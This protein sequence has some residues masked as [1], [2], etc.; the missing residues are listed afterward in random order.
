MRPRS[1]WRTT[2]RQRSADCSPTSNVYFIHTRRDRGFSPALPATCKWMALRYKCCLPSTHTPNGWYRLWTLA[3]CL[4]SFVLLGFHCPSLR[5][6]YVYLHGSNQCRLL[7]PGKLVAVLAL[8]FTERF[9]SGKAM[10]S[11]INGLQYLK[12]FAWLFSTSD[13]I[14]QMCY[15]CRKLEIW[16]FC[17]RPLTWPL[18]LTLFPA[19]WLADLTSDSLTDLSYPI[20]EHSLSHGLSLSE[21]PRW[22]AVWEAVWEA[23]FELSRTRPLNICHVICLSQSDVP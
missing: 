7:A 16:W 15:C 20:R 1:A 19:I 3:L 9:F 22:E 13:W 17:E 14:N 10:K 6:L 5:T 23:E 2:L 21:S 18:T 8:N 12:L 4:Q 11:E